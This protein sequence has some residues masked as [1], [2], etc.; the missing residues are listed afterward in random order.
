MREDV[1]LINI[2]GACCR[3]CSLKNV[4]CLGLRIK[5]CDWLEGSP[6]KLRAVKVLPEGIDPINL[7]VVD[8]FMVPLLQHGPDLYNH[9][10]E[11][12]NVVG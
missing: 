11:H 4:D 6:E 2:L 9:R 1:S 12:D 3:H 7:F 10:A 5:T 8:P